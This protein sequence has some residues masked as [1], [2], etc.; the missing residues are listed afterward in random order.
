MKNW[1][2]QENITTDINDHGARVATAARALGGNIYP[3]KMQFFCDDYEF[4]DPIDVHDDK[5]I[6]YGSCKLT[7]IAYQ[8]N[9]SGLF[10]NEDF[11]STSWNKNRTD[12]LNSD[13]VVITVNEA[14]TFFDELDDT[15][16]RF[17]RPVKDLKEFSGI[18][19]NIGEIKRWMS[20]VDSGNYSFSGDTL[21]SIAPVQDIMG[22]W[23]WFVVNG[24]VID[25]SLYRT[26]GRRLL[27]HETDQ[28]IINEAQK[29]ADVWLPH[30]NCVMDLALTENGVKVIEFNC[31]N[32]SGFYN[33]DIEKVVKAIHSM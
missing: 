12:M 23:R 32:S 2:I 3:I 17:I 24:Q 18:V 28:S 4:W 5:N 7:K 11:N 10:F 31:L 14:K 9:W 13:C 6:V 19:T 26:Y 27:R 16:Q 1:I 25:G 20:S 8:N 29:F 15:Q 30:K 33:H 21:V 22:E